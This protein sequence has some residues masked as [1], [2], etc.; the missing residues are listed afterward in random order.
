MGAICKETHTQPFAAC[1]R[2]PNFCR[3]FMSPAEVLGNSRYGLPRRLSRKGSS[4]DILPGGLGEVI[5]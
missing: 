1:F 2:L 5:E 4:F 3:S